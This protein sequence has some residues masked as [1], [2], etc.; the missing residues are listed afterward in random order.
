M[1]KIITLYSALFTLI[2]TMLPF[3]SHSQ[4]RLMTPR[5]VDTVYWHIRI[6]TI[7]NSSHKTTVGFMRQDSTGYNMT[8]DSVL[9]DYGMWKLRHKDHN[10]I[11][12]LP[13]QND[14]Y[15]IINGKTGDTLQFVAPTTV[16]DTIATIATQEWDMGVFYATT[17]NPGDHNL[18]RYPYD[19]IDYIFTTDASRKVY[20]SERNTTTLDSLWMV[21]ERVK[22]LPDTTH[23]YQMLVDTLES[24]NLTYPYY[25]SAD[26]S[27][28]SGGGQD[29][30]TVSDT[31]REDLSLWTFRIDTLI[32]DTT[33]FSIYNAATGEKLSLASPLEENDTVAYFATTGRVLDQWRIPFFYE[34]D[35]Q[36]ANKIYARDTFRNM[37]FYLALKDSI[38]MLV[39]SLDDYK[40]LKLK[41]MTEDFVPYIPPESVVDSLSVYKVKYL[42]GADSGKYLAATPNNMQTTLDS[43]YNHIPDG[44]FV[45]EHDNLRGL[46]NRLAAV[47]K[48]DSLFEVVDDITGDTIPNVY[49]N[50]H[51]AP[52]TFEVIPLTTMTVHQKTDPYLGFKYIEPSVEALNALLLACVT[53]S[54]NNYLAG[55][56]YSDSILKL[57][58]STGEEDTVRFIVRTAQ[59]YT[60]VGAHAIAGIAALKQSTYLLYALEDSALSIG[61]NGDGVLVMS[62]SSAIPFL[63]REDTIPGNYWLY[64]SNDSEKILADTLTK[65]LHTAPEDTVKTYSFTIKYSVKSIP[66]EPDPYE[67]LTELPDGQGHYE[68]YYYYSKMHQLRWLTKDLENEAVFR[69][70]GDPLT[71]AG[72][73][74]GYDFRLWVDTARGPGFR[75][76]KPSYYIIS[77]EDTTESTFN[78]PGYYLHVCDTITYAPGSPTEPYYVANFIQATRYSADELLLSPG[79]NRRDSVG[80]K[81]KNNKA[82]NEYRFYFQKTDVPG[83]YY[84]VTEAGY[85]GSPGKRGYLSMSNETLYF[86]PRGSNN[87]CAITLKRGPVANEVVAASATKPEVAQQ[88]AAEA[89]QLVVRGSQGAINVLNGMGEQIDAYNIV[90]QRLV[91]VRLNSDNETIPFPRGIAI[92]RNGNKATKVIV[93]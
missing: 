7:Y 72:S 74:T 1:K 54:F 28:R 73:Y 29:S 15:I 56:D 84:I 2:F 22:V 34:E 89:K 44:Q 75:P 71:Y 8:I 82:I 88:T 32:L 30:L 12:G 45:V 9:G 69:R 62:E 83:E 10:I 38:V 77:K 64:D 76:D 24:V 18:I 79:T 36:N 17:F 37:N 93:K 52:D 21:V 46:I 35:I 63:L 87:I 59:N 23:R 48:T 5:D 68:I 31:L 11:T 66:E 43:V 27:L 40:P 3:A 91:S 50:H 47:V 49:T 42:N 70:E 78:V 19:Q 86:G 20:L 33:Y 14:Q 55:F 6:D 85:G 13:I 4:S 80:F 92:V 39:S 25:F 51:A 67:Y 81:G 90:G 57:Q 61:K 16:T 53:D 58:S 41:L 60:G 65:E 26:T